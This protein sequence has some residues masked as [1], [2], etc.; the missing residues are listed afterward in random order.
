MTGTEAFGE[1]QSCVSLV[2]EMGV[3]QHEE[4]VSNWTFFF[5]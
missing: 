5:F 1:G 3:S 2:M 4:I